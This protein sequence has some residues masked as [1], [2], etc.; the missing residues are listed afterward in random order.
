MAT[1]HISIDAIGPTHG[2]LADDAERLAARFVKLLRQRG[3]DVRSARLTLTEG[4]TD[5][6]DE[7]N[8]L[9]LKAVK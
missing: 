2:G 5:V 6:G 4:S 9:P 8:V 7:K 3:H 1:Y